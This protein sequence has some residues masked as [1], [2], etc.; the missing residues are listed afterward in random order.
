[1]IRATF[2]LWSHHNFVL[3]NMMCCP[4]IPG[5]TTIDELSPIFIFVI[6]DFRNT[7]N[8]SN[9]MFIFDR[10][11]WNLKNL[12][13][14]VVAS[15][16]SIR[17]KAT[18]G[19]CRT[20]SQLHGDFIKKSRVWIR[21]YSHIYISWWRHQM[22]TFS[23][24]LAICAGN[25]PVPV[26]FPHKSQWRGALMFSL[27]CVWINGWVNNHEAGDLRRYRIHYDVIVMWDVSMW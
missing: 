8:L 25:S 4:W 13:Y 16:I 26:N 11:Q 3:Y 22:E 27:I 15:Q 20:L 17:K 21:H 1:M 19:A 10:C 5:W 7:V 9:I 12:I 6:N 18:K 2:K 23:A 24:L 14:N